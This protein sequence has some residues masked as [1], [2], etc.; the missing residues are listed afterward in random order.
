MQG[1]RVR[2]GVAQIGG[3][4]AADHAQGAQ[5]GAVMAQGGPELAAELGDRT[6][7]VGAGDRDRRGRLGAEETGAD[8]GEAAPGCGRGQQG[9][10]TGVE[11]VEI[12]VVG[13][14][15]D[16]AARQGI[17]DETAAVGLHAAQRGK[18]RAGRAAARVGADPGH[19]DAERAAHEARLAAV[20]EL[21]KLQG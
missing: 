6:L 15:R 19:F 3:A 10:S 21:R 9:G 5:G 2:R 12:L 1:R 18:Q 16:S 20:N 8:Q 4:R 14:H 13:E 17:A 11:A 7:A